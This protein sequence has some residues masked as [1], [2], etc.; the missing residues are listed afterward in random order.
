MSIAHGLADGDNVGHD[1]LA[2]ELEG[3]HVATDTTE[4]DLNLVGNAE[5]ICGAHVSEKLGASLKFLMV[6]AFDIVSRCLMAQ[7]D[8]LGGFPRLWIYFGSIMK[9]AGSFGPV[10]L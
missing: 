2:V 9:I 3:P 5:A 6:M 10:L 8:I 1:V 7:I 4:A